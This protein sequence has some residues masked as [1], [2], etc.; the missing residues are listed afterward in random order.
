M[1]E[2]II[3]LS[4]AALPG[5]ILCS[6]NGIIAL[7]TQYTHQDETSRINRSR[8]ASIEL[9]SIT[10]RK[11]PLISKDTKALHVKTSF[12]KHFLPPATPSR[13]TVSDELNIC[14]KGRRTV[15]E[16]SEISSSSKWRT[17]CLH[18]KPHCQKVPSESTCTTSCAGSN[19]TSAWLDSFIYQYCVS[20]RVFPSIAFHFR[21]V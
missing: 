2:S 17:Q 6:K 1:F 11:K 19:S 21:M 3:L 12:S 10:L 8:G 9:T 13:A 5:S 20:S 14:E 7:A 4:P 16:P 15:F 18:R